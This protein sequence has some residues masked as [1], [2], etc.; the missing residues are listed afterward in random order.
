MFRL[1]DMD[2]AVALLSFEQLLEVDVADILRYISR[3]ARTTCGCPRVLNYP[4][5]E[6]M[7]G[8]IGT[9]RLSIRA[10]CDMLVVSALPSCMWR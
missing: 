1:T 6:W 7:G 2:I 8:V 4:A 9:E 5:L 3:T 10:G